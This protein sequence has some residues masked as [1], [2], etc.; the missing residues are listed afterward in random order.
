MYL[1][2]AK[3][4]DCESSHYKKN[5]FLIMLKEKKPLT[6]QV[7]I[8]RWSFLLTQQSVFH[9]SLQF[10]ANYLSVPGRPEWQRH[11]LEAISSYS[12][13][14]ILI[15]GYISNIYIYTKH[16]YIPTAYIQRIQKYKQYKSPVMFSSILT[17]TEHFPY[18]LLLWLLL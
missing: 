18:T 6:C 7:A 4:V 13:F 8:L 5:K 17:F 10:D 2:N 14:Y 15:H 16:T 12:V 9:G 11:R 3:R 1:K